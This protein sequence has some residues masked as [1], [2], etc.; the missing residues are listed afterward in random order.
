MLT[1]GVARSPL[2]VVVNTLSNA[3]TAVI[4]LSILVYY[5]FNSPIIS[6][7]LHSHIIV[8]CRSI[9][10]LDFTNVKAPFGFYKVQLTA[11]PAAPD[12]KLLGLKGVVEFKVVTGVKID[13][14]ELGVGDKDQATPKT[15]RYNLIIFLCVL[16]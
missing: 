5:L 8:S 11:A 10:E 4:L 9:F 16:L 7:S 14:V 13:A 3:V 6:T 12:A 15:S 2:A 1:T